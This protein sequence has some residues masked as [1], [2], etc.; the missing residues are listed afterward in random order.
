MK[1]PVLTLIACLVALSLSVAANAAPITYSKDVAPIV[2]NHCISCHKPGEIA[3]FSMLDY[4]SIR[5]WAKSIKQV[6]ADKTM[7]PWHADS[8]QVEYLNDTSLS[9]QQ[10]DT[11]VA[12]VDQG[13]KRGDAA[14]MPE[15]P[16]FNDTWTMGEPDLIFHAER[17]FEV[18]PFE[19][20]IDYQGIHLAPAVDEDLYI[21]AWEIRPTERKSV[22]HAN[23][24]RAP[25]KL[26]SVGI[27]QAVLS[28]GDY[29]GSFLPGARPMAYP[30]GTALK[31]PK[32]SVIQIQVH[33]VGQ[34]EPVTDHVRFGVRLAQG[35]VDQIVRTVGT[36][37][38]EIEIEPNGTFEM[39]TEVTV[40]FPLTFLSSGAHMHTR[41]SAYTASA[42]FPDGNEK[43][44]THVPR[45]DFNWQSNYQLANPIDVPKGTKYHIHAEWD[46]TAKNPTNADPTERVVY[47]RWT[48][49][50][51]LTTWSH[52]ILTDEKLGLRIKDGRLVGKFEDAAD[53]FH[54]PILQTLPNTF[55]MPRKASTDD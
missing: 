29:I 9:Q 50:E 27:G 30:E 1:S 43:L 40:N 36:D 20:E 7:P 6:V 10:I 12:W 5:P 55:T 39:D 37:D 45:Y 22:H 3:P 19:T 4:D 8:S 42:I 32:G 14:D 44:I 11:I 15:L 53:G 16:E 26:E 13:A 28:G 25:R 24:V 46:N 23:L 47:G 54:P 17:D 49:N 52:A 41:G 18:P 21:T 33:Y 51:M 35:R 31:I 34:D 2:F 48:Q 38:Y